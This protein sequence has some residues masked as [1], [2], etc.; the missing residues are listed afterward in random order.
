M[1]FNQIILTAPYPRIKLDTWE[2]TVNSSKLP[3]YHLVNSRNS[4]TC[5]QVSETAA[6][7]HYQFKQYT[8]L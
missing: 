5:I 6:M 3:G 7:N 8:S 4:E 2:D 1:T